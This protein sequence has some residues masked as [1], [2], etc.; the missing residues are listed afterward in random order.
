MEG[1]VLGEQEAQAAEA[2]VVFPGGLAKPEDHAED[3]PHGEEVE[4]FPQARR[5][6]P[7]TNVNLL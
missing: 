3:A 2:L 5:L 6:G 7:E 4:G 1:L